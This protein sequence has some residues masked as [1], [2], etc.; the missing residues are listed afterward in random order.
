VPRAYHHGNLR[1][2][3]IDTA[4]ELARVE[5]PD[6]V[7]LR[8]V[9]RRAGVSHNAAYRHFSD[10]EQL[11]SEVAAVGMAALAQSMRERVAAIRTRDAG[12]RSRRRLREVG[13][14]YVEFAV[15][16]PGLFRVAFAAALPA[17]V[18]GVADSDGDQ[19]E[20]SADPYALLNDA[21][22]ELVAAGQVTP[23]RRVG[24]ELACWAAVHGFAVLHT[25]GPL[26]D[27]TAEE[28]RASLEH[29]LDVVE[30]GLTL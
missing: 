14:A 23:E 26:R 4:V 13:T 19:V 3:L 5:G 2:A 20:K 15:S 9:A 18:L 28:R 10:R 27:A 22:D 16:E 29:M 1:A 8:E 25:D 24:S 11:L 21:L 7:V 6:G 12:K 30:A 17:E